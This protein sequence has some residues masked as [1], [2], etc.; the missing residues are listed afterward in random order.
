MCLYLYR[1]VES[2]IS[3]SNCPCINTN[4]AAQATPPPAFVGTDYF[5]DTGSEER[6]QPIF[7]GDDPLWDGA[8]CG[9]LN[10]CCSFNT[11]PWFYKQLPQSTTSTDDIDMRVCT[12]SDPITNKNVAIQIVEIIIIMSNK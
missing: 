10:T 1:A 4:Q 2:L 12:S 9:P 7:Y 5:C 6:R 8:G 3:S 11:P